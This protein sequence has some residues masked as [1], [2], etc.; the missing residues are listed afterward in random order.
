L[1]TL[2]AVLLLALIVLLPLLQSVWYGFTSWQ[3]TRADWVGLSNYR[4]ILVD[5]ELR[6]S[7]IN[8]LIIFAS[9]PV[10]M[11]GPFVIAYLLHQGMPGARML[12]SII[13]APTALS[14]VVIGVV[15]HEF[16][17]NR[18]FLNGV[19]NIVGLGG[20]TRN[21]LAQ[22]S[23]AL[24]AVII[25]FN[26]AIF[27]VNTIIFL[28]GLA[29]ID[30]ATIEA[31]RLDGANGRQILWYVVLPEMRRFVEFVLIVTVVTGFTG[32]FALVYV[33]TQG[34]PGS[35]SMTLDFA[36]WRRAFATGSFGAGAA[37]GIALMLLTLT[38]IALIR[39][40]FRERGGALK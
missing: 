14:W 13:F 21:W 40:A 4:S 24:W 29:T 31:A 27:G 37:I 9:I 6:R 3:G 5:P 28:T 30:R 2:P 32:L 20:F 26:A 25:A 12:R 35:A 23:F 8:S 34:G 15:A 39:L 7:L 17:A 33:M 1:F 19:M 36:V 18:G 22:Q 10:G 16:F 38:T 11:V